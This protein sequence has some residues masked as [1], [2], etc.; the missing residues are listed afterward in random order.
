MTPLEEFLSATPFFGGLQPGQLAVVARRLKVREVMPGETVF[1][2]REQG[3]SMYVVEAGEL[4][5]WQAAEGRPIRG[6]RRD[7]RRDRRRPFRPKESQRRAR[8]RASQ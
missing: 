5:A 6:C 1:R 7:S 3:K 2:E 4:C 8:G